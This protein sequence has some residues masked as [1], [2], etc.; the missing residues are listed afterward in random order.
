MNQATRTE[1]DTSIN[2]Y[3]NAIIAALFSNAIDA[4]IVGDATAYHML[5]IPLAEN[6]VQQE[7]LVYGKQYRKLLVNKGASIIKGKKGIW[8]DAQ[9]I[10]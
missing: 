4:H 6:L 7:A 9:G 2:A 10:R 3:E 8:S 5:K 1:V